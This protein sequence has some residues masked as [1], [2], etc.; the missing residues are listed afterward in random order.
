[1]RMPMT[2]CFSQLRISATLFALLFCVA[3]GFGMS[4]HSQTQDR[5]YTATHQ[6]LEAVKIV[7][8]QE[9]AWNKG[10]IDGFLSRFK[11]DPETQVMLGTS[12][13]GLAAIRAA[14]HTNYPN[15]EAMGQIGYSDVEA[16]ALGEN[17]ALA[18]GSYH[19]ERSKKT[20]GPADG[21]FTEVMEKTA[22]GWE[23]IFSETT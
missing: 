17:F 11:D 22:K 8:A 1:M 10:D 13:R 2:K 4:G 12:V 7:L 20:G 5:L 9:A 14:F 23:I 19:L 3:T 21:S 16:R 18:T 6:Q 15:H